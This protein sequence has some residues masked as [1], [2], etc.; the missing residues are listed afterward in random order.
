MPYFSLLMMFMIE[1]DFFMIMQSNLSI[2]SSIV[3]AFFLVLF[4]KSF[5]HLRLYRYYSKFFL[6]IFLFHIS[7]LN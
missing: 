1:Q 5:P 3:S 2:F 6:E 4:K 7:H